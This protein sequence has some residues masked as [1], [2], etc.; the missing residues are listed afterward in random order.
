MSY[1]D[2]PDTGR[3]SYDN[4]RAILVAWLDRHK[5]TDFPWRVHPDDVEVPI[6]NTLYTTPHDECLCGHA[7]SRHTRREGTEPEERPCDMCVCAT[8]RN[9]IKHVGK[10]D[11][12]GQPTGASGSY[13]PVDH[14]TTYKIDAKFVRQFDISSQLSGYLWAAGKLCDTPGHQLVAF[15][16]AIELSQ[17]PTSDRRCSKHGVQYNECSLEH[18]NCQ[19]IGPIERTASQ[20]ERWES[21]AITF[22]IRFHKLWSHARRFGADAMPDVP[23]EGTFNNSCGWCEFRE[24]CLFSRST[25][26]TERFTHSPWEPWVHASL[27]KPK[28]TTLYI[29]N[30]IM[31][32][33]ANCSTLTV[34]RHGL[35]MTNPERQGPLNAGTAVHAALEVWFK[36]D[37][38]KKALAAFDEA[39]IPF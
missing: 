31:Q 2:T 30:T 11:L 23:M 38:V 14:K 10:L 36:G 19:V 29:D 21:D 6:V 25:L 20:I 15:I 34:A 5:R 32:S 28:F 22:G 18:M 7:L 33:V 12:L 24:W 3:L 39:Y 17:L 37:S 26:Q 8:Y 4:V 13:C 16:N 9:C 35:H 27:K 1:L